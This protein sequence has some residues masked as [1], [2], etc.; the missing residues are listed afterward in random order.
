MKWQGKSRRKETGGKLKLAKK[1]RRYELGREQN[2]PILGD[3]RHKKVRV[4]G[5]NTR[6]RVLAT[7]VANVTDPKTSTTKK[8]EIKDI[9]ENPANPNYVRRDIITKG[10]VIETE[11]GKARVTSRPGQDGCINAV[12]LKQNA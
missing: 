2:I 6:V 1:K 11:M 4:R 10:A 7:N 5:G 12:L 9:L 8:V 3:A